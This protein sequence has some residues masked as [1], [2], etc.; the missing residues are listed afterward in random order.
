MEVLVDESGHDHEV[1]QRLIDDHFR[2]EELPDRFECPNRFDASVSYGDR[3]G[4][5]LAVAHRDEGAS[6]EDPWLPR[7]FHAR[8]ISPLLLKGA[9][10]AFK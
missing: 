4:A 8:K 6:D 9:E 2:S 5:R 10:T 1:F 7:R 3:L